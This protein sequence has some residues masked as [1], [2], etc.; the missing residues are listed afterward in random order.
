MALLQGLLAV[1]SRMTGRSD[2]NIRLQLA[3]KEEEE[4]WSILKV[5]A[6]SSDRKRMGIIVRNGITKQIV[7]FM[8]V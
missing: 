4:D 7:L 2:T 6:F 8:K 3:G 5:N 1:G